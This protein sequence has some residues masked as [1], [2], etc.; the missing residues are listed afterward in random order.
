LWCYRLPS[1]SDIGEIGDGAGT[2]TVMV[3]TEGHQDMMTGIIGITT[4]G[5]MISETI[6]NRRETLLQL[7]AIEPDIKHSPI[8]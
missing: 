5:T 1:A 6:M 8:K 2:K 4:T 7:I 3:L